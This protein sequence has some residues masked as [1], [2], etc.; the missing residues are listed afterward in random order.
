MN[1]SLIVKENHNKKRVE[2]LC[3]MVNSVLCIPATKAVCERFFRSISLCV[4]K[5]YMTNLKCN[6]ACIIIYLNRY[7]SL[8]Y[9]I[10]KTNGKCRYF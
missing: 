4:K 1:K 8:V 7:C 3:D 6:K 2:I 10:L 9:D 5:Q